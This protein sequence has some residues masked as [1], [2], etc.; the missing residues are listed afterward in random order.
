[1]I[2][3]VTRN[4]FPQ[5]YEQW[6]SW[7]YEEPE[8]F[9]QLMQQMESLGILLGDG[10][11]DIGLVD[12][13]LGSFVTTTWEKFKPL[14]FEL[15]ERNADPYLAEYFQ[16]MAEQIDTRMKENPRKPFYESAR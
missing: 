15:R 2:L 3:F 4:K 12:K 10:L 14:V 9:V 7:S 5:N 6:Q 16:W 1:M 11:I 8:L 13:T